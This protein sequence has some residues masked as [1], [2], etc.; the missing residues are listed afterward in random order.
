M[1]SRVT[2]SLVI[3][4]GGAF[5][6]NQNSFNPFWPIQGL[7]AWGGSSTLSSVN[8]ARTPS[9]SPLSQVSSYFL[10][11][12]LI[13]ATSSR[14]SV[15]WA[16]PRSGPASR[17]NRKSAVLRKCIKPPWDL[18]GSTDGRWL[19][20]GRDNPGLKAHDC[21]GCLTR[22]PVEAFG[23]QTT[24]LERRG[25]PFSVRSPRAKSPGHDPDGQRWARRCS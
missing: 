3:F 24:R 7:P 11:T 8:N 25:S 12:I 21:G 17:K 6:G 18:G 13:L 22:R 4:V 10:C 15:F 5:G 16:R 2:T 23:A 9:A 1:F 19:G 20:K 14:E